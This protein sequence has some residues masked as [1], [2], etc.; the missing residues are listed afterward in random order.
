[1]PHPTTVRRSG[2]LP[3]ALIIS[4]IFAAL[5][6]S[7]A[8]ALSP[9]ETSGVV[10]W[11]KHVDTS[12]RPGA[13]C[14]YETIHASDMGYEIKLDRIGVRP[15]KMRAVNGSQNVGWRI[16]VWRLRSGFEPTVVAR[17]PIQKATATET[18]TAE[19]A[20]RPHPNSLGG[21]AWGP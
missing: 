12:D 9:G 3:V 8:A 19:L 16:V 10:G 6:A 7:P 1:M 18:R 4:A 17:S 2:T 13:V 14:R 21:R 11:Y 20:G 5:A 15:P